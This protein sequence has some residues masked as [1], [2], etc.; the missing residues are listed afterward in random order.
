MK[1]KN[2]DGDCGF[3][4]HLNSRSRKK[5]HPRSGWMIETIRLLRHGS[6]VVHT[7]YESLLVF[8]MCAA[9]VSHVQLIHIRPGHAWWSNTFAS[10]ERISASHTA[11][12]TNFCIVHHTPT[13]FTVNPTCER[14]FRVHMDVTLGVSVVSMVSFPP[15]TDLHH[16][17]TDA[18]LFEREITI[19]NLSRLFEY[20]ICKTQE[21]D[22]RTTRWALLTKI[23]L[24]CPLKTKNNASAC[25]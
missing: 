3:R 2:K 22:K 10:F 1:R 5:N 24:L 14:I 6:M 18:S 7:Y 23:H 12:T 11:S 9:L 13:R 15:H 25:K 19:S 21:T 17:L 20:I 4:S 8:Y 16:H